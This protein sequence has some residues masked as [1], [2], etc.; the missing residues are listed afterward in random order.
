[1]AAA[2]G[3][4]VPPEYA[5]TPG[6]YAGDTG[7]SSAESG[8][9]P[10]GGGA[11]TPRLPRNATIIDQSAYA[12]GSMTWNVIML[13]SNGTIDTNQENWNAAEI[14]L[15]QTEVNQ[16]K[17]YWEGLTA[18]FHPNA[19]LSID[20]HYENAAVPLATGYE[21]ITRPH[22][23]QGL[24]INQVMGTLGYNTGDHFARVRNYNHARRI[25]DN[26]HWATTIFIVDDTADVGNDFS[27]GW[28]AYAYFGGPFTVLTQGNDGW[29]ETNFNMVLSHEMGHIFNALD[30]YAASGVRNT[31]RA[32]YLNGLTLNAS[33]DGNGNTVTPPQPNAVMRNNGNFNTGVTHP[34]HSSSSVN[35]GHRDIDGDTIPDILDTPPTLTGNAAGSDAEYG[36]FVFTGSISVNDFNNQN[37]L[38]VGITNSLA[39]MTINTIAGAA[40]SL[41]GGVPTPFPSNDGTHDDYT[42]GLGFSI[43]GLPGGLHTINV[44]G[45]D[46][47]GNPSNLLQ[48]QFTS[49]V[50]E[51]STM[52]LVLLGIIGLGNVRRGRVDL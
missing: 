21:P 43:L 17:T 6:V 23:Q 22:T 20:V 27:D 18:G 1:L 8:S 15:I 51:P 9:G 13:E 16:A 4:E 45:I 48:F 49:L 36:N 41:D 35:F 19:R 37:P 50:P 34:P 26:N 47:V 30:E 28:F 24:W 29:N 31:Q 42:E 25:A 33:L 2:D 5:P 10:G 7:G 38:S 11:P 44:F 32:G 46:S 39:D 3:L 40:Y 12:L 14:A 52:L